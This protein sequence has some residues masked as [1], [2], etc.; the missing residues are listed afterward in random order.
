MKRTVVFIHKTEIYKTVT[1]KM[2]PV[3]LLVTTEPIPIGVHVLIS[4]K[5]NPLPFKEAIIKPACDLTAWIE[6]YGYKK[7]GDF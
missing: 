6:G 7:V 4:G 2:K 5:R 3:T 1:G